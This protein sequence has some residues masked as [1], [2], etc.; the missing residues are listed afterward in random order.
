MGYLSYPQF[1]STE[2]VEKLYDP[3]IDF[4][5]AKN[6]LKNL[7]SRLRKK[8]PGKIHCQS[9]IYIFIQN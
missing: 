7:I 1:T 5:S 8:Y 9:N 4:F 3:Q 6:R 2:L